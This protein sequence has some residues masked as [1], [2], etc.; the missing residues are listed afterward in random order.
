MEKVV[1][2]TRG[3]LVESV[4]RGSIAVADAAG[5]LMAWL[6]DPEIVTYYRSS[7]KPIQAIPVITSGAAQRFGLKEEEL[8]IIC[9]SHGGEE[10]HIEIITKLLAKLGLSEEY[11]Q[12]GVHPPMYANRA[13]ELWRQGQEPSTIHCNCSG[14]HSGMLAICKHMGWPLE[15]YL[16]LAH[17]LQQMLLKTIKEYH[18]CE[19]VPVGIDGCGVP[20]YGMSIRNMAK[21]YARLVQNNAAEPRQA[22]ASQLVNA[23]TKYPKLVAGTGR[24]DTIL[25][26]KM[27]KKVVTKCG[28]EGVQCIGLRDK[29]LGIAIKIEDGNV[30]G[31]EP[32]AI[33]VLR[34]LG[35]LDNAEVE[36]LGT[37]LRVPIKNH[38]REVIGELRPAFNLQY[39][40]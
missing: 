20:V 7:A 34:Q 9:A 40:S 21:G 11:L 16:D 23:M 5:N 38:R 18:D 39:K 22:A 36:E 19:H 30:R 31:T 26:T 27:G 8:A 4:H 35:V 14:K 17:P 32:V 25:M 1:E 33:E 29:G 37:L 3:P 10:E 2:V 28:A 6:G 13:V 24:L 15:S 12:C